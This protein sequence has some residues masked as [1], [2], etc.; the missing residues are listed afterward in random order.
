MAATAVAGGEGVL[1]V[2]EAEQGEKAWLCNVRSHTRVRPS[3][4][5]GDTCR[6]VFCRYAHNEVLAN[7]GG[8]ASATLGG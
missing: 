1:V 3:V 6:L 4:S 5:P 7:H 2:E 8:S